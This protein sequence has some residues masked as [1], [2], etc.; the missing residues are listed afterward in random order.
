VYWDVRY[1]L[2]LSLYM[3]VIGLLAVRAGSVLPMTAMIIVV[4]QTPGASRR[5]SARASP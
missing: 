3:Q 5:G 1:F 2:F 4:A